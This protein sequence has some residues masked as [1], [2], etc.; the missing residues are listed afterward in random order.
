MPRAVYDVTICRNPHCTCPDHARGNVC[1]HILFTML[2]VLRLAQDNPIVWQRA[3]LTAE[4]RQ[5]RPC[6]SGSVQAGVI[7]PMCQ[8]KLF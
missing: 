7:K 2:R 8:H 6:A 5:P 4:V 1:K 3:L